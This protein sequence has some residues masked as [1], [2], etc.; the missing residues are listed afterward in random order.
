MSPSRS[1]GPG[2]CS[3][4]PR[5]SGDEPPQYTM[6]TGMVTFSPHERG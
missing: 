3:R 1:F 2:T 5:M 6:T 4:F